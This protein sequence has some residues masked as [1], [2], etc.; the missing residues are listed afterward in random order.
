MASSYFK[1]GVM[2]CWSTGVMLSQHSNTPILHHSSTFKTPSLQTF[3]LAWI[4][5]RHVIEESFLFEFLKK[6]QV[7]KLL[8]FGVLCLGHLLCQHVEHELNTFES[9][10][11]LLRDHLDITLVRIFENGRI[12]GPHVLREDFLGFFL[13]GVNKIDRLN[14]SFQSG[15]DGVPI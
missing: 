1:N 14:E 7:N 9:R 12:V 5:F 10:I 13:I 8:G 2:E 15:F 3:L 11:G 6:T 4:A